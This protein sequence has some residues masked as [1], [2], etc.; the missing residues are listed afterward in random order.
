MKISIV[1]SEDVRAVIG[2]IPMGMARVILF[3]GDRF[4]CCDEFVV[5]RNDAGMVVA[6][7]SLAPEGEQ[8]SGEP[9]IVGVWVAKAER[10]KRLGT[11]IFEAAVRRMV[12]R[13]FPKVRVDVLSRG[14][15][16]VLATMEPGLREKLEMG[17]NS[18]DIDFPD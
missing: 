5:G 17:C 15:A 9:T 8:E 2:A 7:A 4:S 10:R 18:P 6:L 3:G 16:G 13:G 12:A 14:M 11:A 1:R